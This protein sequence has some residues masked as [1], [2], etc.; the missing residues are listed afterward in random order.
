MTITL[1]QLKKAVTL[2]FKFHTT[3]ESD[4]AK[5]VL[6]NSSIAELE[7]TEALVK[8]IEELKLLGYEGALTKETAKTKVFT[9]AKLFPPN[10]RQ[11]S[12]PEIV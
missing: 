4:D 5:K 10:D 6:G 8:A 12:I 9:V 7:N 11:Q 2:T 1:K 3:E